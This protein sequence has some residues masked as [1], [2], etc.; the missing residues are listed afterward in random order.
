MAAHDWFKLDFK[1]RVPCQ[2]RIAIQAELIKC[3]KLDRSVLAGKLMAKVKVSCA[4]AR[5]AV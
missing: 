4:V 2:T 3:Y 5:S 1:I